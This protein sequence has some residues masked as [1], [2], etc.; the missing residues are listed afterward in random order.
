MSEAADRLAT[1]LKVARLT[2]PARAL[3]QEAVRIKGRLDELD[4]VL[5]GEPDAWLAIVE[6]MPPTVAEVTIV[7]PLAEARQQALALAAVLKAL[8]SLAEDAGKTEE[9]PASTA[10]ELAKRRKER[11]V[12]EAAGGAL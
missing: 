2:G 11:A 10:D 9:K 12:A 6:R 3:A 5:T 8:H 1:D 4:R 7:K